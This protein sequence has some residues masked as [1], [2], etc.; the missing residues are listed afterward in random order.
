MPANR[1]APSFGYNAGSS[2]DTAMSGMARGGSA[3]RAASARGRQSM[4]QGAGA[5]AGAARRQA[6]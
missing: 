5:A 6:R 3:E 4:P 1:P 2:R